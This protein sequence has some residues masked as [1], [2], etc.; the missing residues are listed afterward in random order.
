MMTQTV[1][2]PRL[3]PAKFR[4]PDV[5]ADGSQRA[6]VQLVQLET[7][8]FNTGTICNLECANCY[9]ESSPRNDRL[10]YLSATAVAVF[11]DEIE[12]EG[13]GTR[14]IGFTGGEPFMNPEIVVMLEAA[15]QRGFEVLVLTNGMRPM[16]KWSD[17]LL[18][19]RETYGDRLTL[20]V[21]VDHYTAQLHE[22]ERGTRSWEPMIAGLRWLSAQDFHLSAAGRTQWGDDEADLRNGYRALFASHGIAIDAT[23][24]ANLILFPEMDA[25]A[26]VPEITTACWSL[27]GQSPDDIMCASSRM[28]VQRRNDSAP[29]VLSCTLLPYDE[30]FEMG[31]TLSA[32]STAVKLNHPHCATF[33]VLGHASCSS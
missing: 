15:L 11:L 25:N 27:L 9:I 13:L 6:Q 30:G 2:A 3:D 23:D 28:V 19:L 16:M 1:T 14:E 26:D 29:V 31:R 21:S 4:D 10:A 7:L 17:E 24:P 5:T 18:Q 8:W 20:R 22:Q 33:C 12:N 32:A